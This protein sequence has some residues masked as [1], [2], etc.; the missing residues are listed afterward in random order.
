MAEPLTVRLLL[1][2]TLGVPKREVRTRPWSTIALLALNTM[3][4]A[5]GIGST[6]S[7]AWPSRRYVAT[8]SSHCRMARAWSTGTVRSIHG[9]I[10]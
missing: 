5:P 6:I 9:L 3:S 10:E 1:G 2:R 8:S 4:G 7:T